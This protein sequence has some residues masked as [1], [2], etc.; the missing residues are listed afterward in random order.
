MFPK[1]YK[2]ILKKVQ[3]RKNYY[4]RERMFLL[5]H[6]RRQKSYTLQLWEILQKGIFREKSDKIHSEFQ[7]RS[8]GRAMHI[9]T[10]RRR[11]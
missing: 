1:L 11:V 6:R 9:K 3:V 5:S 8:T 2:K 7:S 10:L 4:P